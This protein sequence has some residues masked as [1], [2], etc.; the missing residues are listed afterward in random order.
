M[1]AG[2]ACF[3]VPVSIQTN[4]LDDGLGA[5]CTPSG[6]SCQTLEPRK[7]Q[8]R[9]GGWIR[10]QRET[11][12]EQLSALFKALFPNYNGAS[13]KT[14]PPVRLTLTSRALGDVLAVQCAG[15]IVAGR[16]SETLHQH[17]KQAIAETPDIVLTLDKV[18]FID[19]SG[20]GALVRL[21]V[22][23]RALGGDIKLCA[24]P[25]PILNTLRITNLCRV[26]E[27]YE[28]ESDAVT[29]SYQRNSHAG[30]ATARST[31][32]VLCVE[33]SPD[34]LSYLSEVLRGAGLRPVSGRNLPD[35]IVLCKAA[36]PAAVIMG[37]GVPP[38]SGKP[39]RERLAEIDP[40]IPIISLDEDFLSLDA[41]EAAARVLA[42]LRGVIPVSEA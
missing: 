2:W 9:E 32:T 15:R 8:C 37:P 34:L 41:G 19:S 30:S 33:E 7:K 23:A 39:A 14:E 21:A 42:K 28:S 35:A 10:E 20:L 27:T 38:C 12:I 17:L 36:K 18:E 11:I 5:H 22:N 40:V 24:L 26:L 13:P 16:E 31:K 29:A 1:R 6:P 3:T 4:D 25:P